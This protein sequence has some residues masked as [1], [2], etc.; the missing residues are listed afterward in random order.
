MARRLNIL[1]L[2]QCKFCGH[3]LKPENL[4]AHQ[5]KY[6][7]AE[8]EENKQFL[9]DLSE[10]LVFRT[11]EKYG[12]QSVG[13]ADSG[14]TTVG[15]LDN[16]VVSCPV[17]QATGQLSDLLGHVISEHGLHKY[18]YRKAPFHCTICYKKVRLCN[19]AEHIHTFHS[20]GH[21]LVEKREGLLVCPLC[22]DDV[23]LSSDTS[24]PEHILRQ[25]SDE[26]D[27]NSSMTVVCLYCFVEV[28]LKKYAR[29][30]KKIHS[31]Q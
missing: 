15:S 30:Y 6:H 1:K 9:K 5:K 25:H 19:L 26:I 27:K 2:R 14:K 31:P 11:P 28:Q 8:Y 7:Q 13:N 22:F 29:H 17:C 24:W 20:S 3:W 16:T 18:P 23:R 4:T 10:G 12:L 21:A